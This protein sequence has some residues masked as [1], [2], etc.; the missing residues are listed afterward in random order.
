MLAVRRTSILD[1]FCRTRVVGDR[2][3]DREKVEEVLFYLG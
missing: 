3:L 1:H 2:M